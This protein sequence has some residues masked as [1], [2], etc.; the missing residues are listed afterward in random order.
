MRHVRSLNL[1][2][3][4]VK[5]LPWNLLRKGFTQTPLQTFFVDLWIYCS[6][7]LRRH[8]CLPAWTI[9]A[10]YMNAY[11]PLSHV[12]HMKES[13]HIYEWVTSQMSHVKSHVCLSVRP[14]P[15]SYMH[16][17]EYVM[18]YKWM[19]H[20]PYMNV[21]RHINGWVMAHTWMCHVKPYA[22]LPVTCIYLWK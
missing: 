6:R 8:E 13:D 11:I 15:V 5:T 20:G 4:V 12:T 7:S 1:L 21:A 10:A 18:S 2:R 16:K 19:S 17:Y 22:R 9:P 3:N 14:S